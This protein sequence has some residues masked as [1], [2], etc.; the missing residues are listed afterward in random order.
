MP[1]SLAMAIEL[2]EFDITAFD[3]AKIDISAPEW[4]SIKLLEYLLA[5]NVANEPESTA[6]RAIDDLRLRLLADIVVCANLMRSPE[7]G[8]WDRELEHLVLEQFDDIHRP[9]VIEAGGVSHISIGRCISVGIPQVDS[10]TQVEAIA[11]AINGL[12]HRLPSLSHWIF[13]LSDVKSITPTLLAYLIGFQ[14]GISKSGGNLALLWVR[15]EAVSPE[16]N[17]VM[18]RSF[19]LA[20]KGSFLVSKR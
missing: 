14:H 5:N 19:Q 6:A 11:N 20:K 2:T 4:F 9:L 10:Y 16:I 18:V 1:L 15:R 7:L 8:L 3:S 12:H 13:D 17:G